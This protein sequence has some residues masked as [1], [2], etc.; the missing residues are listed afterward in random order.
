MPGFGGYSQ[1]VSPEAEAL[2]LKVVHC[3]KSPCLF[4]CH[5]EKGRGI[6]NVYDYIEA[7]LLEPDISNRWE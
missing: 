1:K 6:F 4:R 3:K 5:A 2:F 7:I